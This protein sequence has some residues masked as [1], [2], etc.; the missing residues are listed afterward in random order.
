MMHDQFVYRQATRV[1]GVG[2]IIQAALALFLLVFGNLAGDTGLIL[3]G[4]YVATGILSWTTLTVLFYQH[5]LERVESLENEEVALARGAASSVFEGERIEHQAAARRLR[6]MHQWLAPIASLLVAVMLGFLCY[7]TLSWLARQDSVTNTTTFRVGSHLGWQLALCT[8][9]SLVTFIFSRFVA[10]MAKQ[11]AWQNLRGGAG[12]M[13]GNAL[14]LLAL[15]VG[16]VFQ[17]FKKDDV[18]EAI[19]Y[20][21]AIYVG[22]IAAE[23]LLNL[24]LNLYR[25]RKVSD[26]PRPAFD[27]KLLGLAA[28]PDSIVRSINEAVNYQFGFDITSSWG[29]QLLLRSVLRL[30]TLGVVVLLIMSMI[31]VVQPSEQAVRLRGGRVIGGVAQGS[32][33]F[34]WPW[35]IESVERYDIDQIRTLVLGGNLL[36]TS[37]VNLWPV[38]GEPDSER[39]PF[40][41]LASSLQNAA[42]GSNVDGSASILSPTSAADAA[43]V[44]NQFALID[45]DIVLEYRVRTDGLLD[46]LQFCGDTR[47]RGSALDMRER[48]LKAIA[49]RE[50]SQLFSTRSIDQVLS[51]TGDSLVSQLTQRVQGA[52]DR[53]RSGV[54]VLGILL[55][56][57][58]PPAGEAAGMFEELSIDVQNAR[59]IVDEANRM[60]NVTLSTLAGNPERAHAIVAAIDQLQTLERLHGSDAPAA[61]EQRAAVEKMIIDARA[62]A[63][64][65]ISSA[66]ARRWDALM[67]ARTT[68]SEVLG[69]A[70]SYHTAP[71]IYRE[72]AIMAVLTRALAAARIKYVLA[73]DPSRVEFDIQ[74]EQ[75]EPGLN[76]GDYLE[77]KE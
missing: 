15:A 23:I 65:V 16:T 34:K 58:R 57:L 21:I 3:A 61:R 38:D 22:V 49:M 28:A 56:V 7:G 40:I 59:K 77:K 20:G 6:L 2:V 32:L 18:L 70:A 9:L 68:S 69:Q 51:P 24:I 63:A 47:M 54:E 60:L 39:L 14:V 13:V 36:P 26:T 33:L 64:S 27:S 46:Y 10:G 72:R 17:V 53:S 42:A 45:A 44:S 4:L 5:K 50:A 37:S 25:P 11:P 75:P 30:C 66:R 35:P 29:Y 67:R 76:L 19:A 62:Q 12:V 48:V 1:S 55:P 73:V 31:V 43:A 52:F 74:M 8:A 71:E 41:V